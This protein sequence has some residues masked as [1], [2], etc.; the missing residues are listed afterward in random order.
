MIFTCS[1]RLETHWKAAPEL[2]IT[3]T[4]STG[5]IQLMRTIIC[6]SGKAVL[7]ELGITVLCFN[8][9]ARSRDLGLTGMYVLIAF[10]FRMTLI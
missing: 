5:L 6:V 2:K 3:Y 1:Y 8:L 9:T 7:T 4:F 10:E